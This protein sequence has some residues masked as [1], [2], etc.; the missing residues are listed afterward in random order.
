MIESLQGYLDHLQASGASATVAVGVVLI[1]C[2]L[3]I[4]LKGWRS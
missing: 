4:A 1:V 3:A 2:A